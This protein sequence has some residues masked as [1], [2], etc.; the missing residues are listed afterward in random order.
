MIAIGMYIMP[1]LATGLE[2]TPTERTSVVFYLEWYCIT[3][4]HLAIYFSWALS[5]YGYE[6]TLSTVGSSFRVILPRVNQEKIYRLLHRPFATS[7]HMHNPVPVGIQA[8]MVAL[9]SRF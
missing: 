9:A 4:V 2:S 8:P 6:A 7:V 1:I 3:I 5:W